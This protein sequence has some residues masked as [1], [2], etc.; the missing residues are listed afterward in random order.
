MI[1]R[2]KASSSRQGHHLYERRY[3]DLVRRLDAAA[4]VK[5]GIPASPRRS[6]LLVKLEGTDPL[7]GIQIVRRLHEALPLGGDVCEFGVA[8]GRTSA[9]LAD[10]ILLSGAAAALHLFDSFVGLPAP[11]REDELLDDIFALGTI[12]AYE[13]RMSVSETEVKT[14]MDECGFKNYTIW[15]GFI[16]ENTTVPR[17][18]SFAY[19]DMDFF[20]PTLL[21]L[22]LL[23]PSLVNGGA[24]VVDDY[25]YFSSGIQRAVAEFVS[26]RTD[27]QLYEST[28]GAGPFVTLIKVAA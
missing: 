16:N 27:V 9:L 2:L 13:G 26:G 10:E 8:Q 4:I 3:L 1:R 19:L 28:P 15:K 17:C 7:E 21:G 22:R 23:W 24:A 6:S 12:E 5:Y 20:E 14:R 11:S 25:G 18:I